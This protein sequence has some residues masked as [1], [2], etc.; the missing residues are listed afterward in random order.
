MAGVTEEV[1]KVVERVNLSIHQT[2][3]R[4]HQHLI[5]LLHIYG[6][7]VTWV[8]LY[9]FSELKRREQKYQ[10]LGS[11]EFWREYFL[12]TLVGDGKDKDTFYAR[13]LTKELIDKL[14]N[15]HFQETKDE[16]S[17]KATQI[18][19]SIVE[20]RRLIQELDEK[21]FNKKANENDMYNY[22]VRPLKVI[23]SHFERKLRDYT[24]PIL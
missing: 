14:R 7:V 5:G 20:R 1:N 18:L 16:F 11:R 21:L 17:F 8:Y 23:E 4:V 22:I 12:S 9:E 15:E 10:S 3:F 19:N 13:M 6:M 24:L 2:A